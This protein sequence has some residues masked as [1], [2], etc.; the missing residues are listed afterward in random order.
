M[1]FFLL[2][3]VFGL[4]KKKKGGGGRELSLY[5]HVWH[6][7]FTYPCLVRLFQEIAWREL[8]K[9]TAAAELQERLRKLALRQAQVH[10][11]AG[12]AAAGDDANAGAAGDLPQWVADASGDI[13]DA[14]DADLDAMLMEAVRTSAQLQTASPDAQ[15]SKG[16]AN[17]RL[18]P[19]R[20]QKFQPLPFVVA[21]V[22][23]YI[24][25][26]PVQ[27]N[28]CGVHDSDFAKEASENINVGKA[29]MAFVMMRHKM[30]EVDA[31]RD[32]ER[33]KTPM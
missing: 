15:V 5:A 16:D 26:R 2:V 11:Q 33:K 20:L 1:A 24:F 28:E 14:V 6:S 21:V 29:R 27:A 23:I 10:A 13:A 8:S 22:Y 32:E 9:K 7:V 19:S 25:P 17:S 4:E 30:R 18:Q 12:G 3:V 31:I